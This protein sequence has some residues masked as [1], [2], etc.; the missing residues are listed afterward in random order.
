MKRGTAGALITLIALLLVAGSARA[1]VV[2]LCHP[3]IANDPCE[4][5]L[6]TT[7][8]APGGGSRAQTP[9]RVPE[10]KRSVDC[11][12]VYPTVSNQLTLNSNLTIDPEEDSIAEWQAARFSSVCRVFAPMYRQ[13]TTSG[14]FGAEFLPVTIPGAPMAVAYSGVLAAWQQYMAEDNHGRGVIL[15]GHSQGAI[16][17]EQLIRT[18]IDDNPRVRRLLVGA[19]IEGGQVNVPVGKTT[20]GDF[21]HVPICAERGEFGCVVAYSSYPVNPLP[22]SILGNE[23]TDDDWLPF[24][25][26][27]HGAGYQIACTDPGKLSGLTGPFGLTYPS[28]P[29]APGAISVGLSLT[30]N[31]SLPSAPTTWIEPSWR[32]TGSCQSI[33]GANVFRYYPVGASRQFG[34]YPPTWGSHLFDLNLGVDRLTTIARLQT[35]AWLSANKPQVAACP[36]P[37][38]RLTGRTLGP[39]SLGTSRTRARAIFHR[40]STRGRADM[41]FYCLAGGSVIRAGYPSVKLLG[42]L[43][44]AVRARLRG[45]VILLLTANHHYTLDGV[46]LRQRIVAAARRLKLE[47]PFHIGLNTWYLARGRLATGVLEVRHGVIQEI[48]I[49]NPALTS[50]RADAIQFL[51]SF[52]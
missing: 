45:R 21:Q 50:K 42:S 27:Q 40:Y 22:F 14:L 47:A 13:V 1:N 28:K 8:Y 33:N 5:P 29:F 41:D 26:P 19:F 2:W 18:Q 43:S 4:I 11:F 24:G 3:G 38:G 16:M 6:T 20:G 25:W 10:A 37:S 17:L 15:I 36:K 34:E 35:Q 23:T 39:L 31:G 46:R 32:Y 12:Y 44:P 51:T 9:S 7:V 49:A 48:G 52:S 30:A